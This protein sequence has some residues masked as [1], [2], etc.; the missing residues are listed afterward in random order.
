MANTDQYPSL[1]TSSGS[2]LSCTCLCLVTNFI[3]LFFFQ[4]MTKPVKLLIQA[5]W[6]CVTSPSGKVKETT[7]SQIREPSVIGSEDHLPDQPIPDPTP[8]LCSPSS[9]QSSSSFLPL[10]CPCCY[11]MAVVLHYLY[12]IMCGVFFNQQPT[13]LH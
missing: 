6:A 7:S 2:F 11:V 1:P 8:A 12:K 4:V 9:A 13:K 10:L 5:V 3:R